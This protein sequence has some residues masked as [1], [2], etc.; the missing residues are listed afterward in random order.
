MAAPPLIH[1][2]DIH[3]TFGGRPLFDGAEL[4]LGERERICLVGRN[5]SGKS[6]LLKVAAGLVEPDA[7]SVFVQPG[8]TVRYLPQ[9]PDFEGFTTTGDYV[10][11]GLTPGDDP[12]RAIALLQDLGMTGSENPAKLSGGEARRVA[13][14]RVLAPEP[15]VLLLDE[16]TNHLDLTAIER[17]ETVLKTVRSAIV[18][19]SH[20]R[21]FLENLSE[22]TIWLD[23]GI[24]LRLDKG[25]AHFETWRDAVLEAEERESHKLDRKIV[26]E[27]H[28]LRYGV[29]ARRK[30]NQRRLSEL[31]ALRD[32]QRRR[33]TG[34]PVGNVVLRQQ[35]TRRSGKLVIE[36]DSLAK[37]YSGQPIVRDFS[38]KIERGE[39]IGIIG[40][41]GA[42]KT[43][44]VNL[45][46]G[47]LA[48]DDGRVRVGTALDIATLDQSRESLD[49]ELSVADTLTGGRGD[50]VMIG[51][52]PRHVI[53]YMKDFLFKPDQAR[54]P[55]SALSGG[56][57]GRLVLARALARPSNLLVLDEPTND[58]DLE[59]LDLLQ[60]MLSDYDGTLILVSHDR[61]FIDRV[62]TS[63]IVSEGDGQWQDYAGGYSDMLAQR[64]GA[65][66]STAT[67]PGMQKRNGRKNRKEQ[68]R[69]TASSGGRRKLTYKDQHALQTLPGKI[70][71]L[72]AAIETLES[73]LSDSD[74]YNRDP[75]GFAESTA[76]L[77]KAG[78]DLADAE[79]EW[80][81]IE[82]LREEMDANR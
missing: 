68:E 18:M 43:T 29:T 58:L 22:A 62:V 70:E 42:G 2:Q 57:K 66:R 55:V 3:L 71:E 46:T 81:R 61:D 44:L 36:A 14:A 17:L 11:A 47:K 80:L 25:F 72:S 27:E 24:T 31:H 75:D 48:P 59:T 82:L 41:N 49:S 6:T 38:V 8:L 64:N 28:W 53:G 52:S 60:D 10:A 9:E 35:E 16:P 63:V 65:D 39:K 20:D 76:A 67:D 34:R 54:T 69:G 23:R 19:I 5:G 4:Q 30:R 1:L 12:Y 26:R 56:E 13:I 79:E 15:D 73:K 45:L 7:G 37:S 78:R 74:F 21:R 50:Q 40:P 77:E 51:N 33:R 32:E